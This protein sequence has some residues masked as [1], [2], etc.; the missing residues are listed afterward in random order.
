VGKRVFDYFVFTS[1]YIALCAVLMT[2]QTLRMAG[3]DV[4]SANLLCFIFFSTICS[5]NFHWYLTTNSTTSSERVMW[6]QNHKGLHVILYMIGLAG[7]L[8]YFYLLKDHWLAIFFA[9]LVTFLYSAPKIPQGF[10][11]ELKKIA[12]GKTFLLAF[13]WTYVTAGLPLAILD[14]RLKDGL[15]FFMLSRFFL[16]YSIC[17]LFDYRD[18]NDDR[19]DNIKSM[20]TFLNAKGIDILFYISLAFFAAATT[21][22][23]LYGFSW[24]FVLVQLAPGLIVV[25][26]YDYAKRHFSDYLY[27]VV[28]DGLMMLSA[29]IALVF[30]I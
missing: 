30:R 2:I 6:T 28:L 4:A 29:L 11:K 14:I 1:L 16:I 13:V 18:R 15:L 27:Y 26:L 25:L 7:S 5:Y 9:A 24:L 20:I 19:R 21:C 12:I 17:I 3:S 10:F 8:F 23:R 22:L